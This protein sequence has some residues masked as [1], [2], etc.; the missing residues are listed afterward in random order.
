MPP[1]MNKFQKAYIGSLVI[2]AVLHSTHY[3]LKDSANRVLLDA[4]HIN[5]LKLAF[6]STLSGTVNTQ[7]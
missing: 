6:V 1:N 5:R 2:D 7:S 3:K 4:S